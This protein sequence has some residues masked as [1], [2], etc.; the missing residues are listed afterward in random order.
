MQVFSKDSAS[1]SINRLPEPAA[2]RR[3]SPV[4]LPGVTT[5]LVFPPFL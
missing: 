1:R 3:I 4:V 5:I 2:Q